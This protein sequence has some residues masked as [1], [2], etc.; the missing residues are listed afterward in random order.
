MQRDYAVLKV[1]LMLGRSNG[2][3]ES[4]IQRLKLLKRRMY[5]QAGFPLLRKRVLHRAPVLPVRHKRHVVGPAAA[6]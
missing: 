3:T 1:G 2:Q 4:Q 6:A 5:G